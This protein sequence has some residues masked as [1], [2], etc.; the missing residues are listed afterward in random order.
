MWSIKVQ[1]KFLFFLP[2]FVA[3]SIRVNG[4]YGKPL[5][6]THENGLTTESMYSCA[7]D[8]D[9]FIWFASETG[10]TRFNGLNFEHFKSNEGLVSNSVLYF[11]IDSE[12]R[13][14][15]CTLNG[16]INYYWQ[17]KWY[18]KA[19]NIILGASQKSRKYVGRWLKVID[20]FAIS[21]I[22]RDIKFLY[23]DKN[24]VL[25]SYQMRN[26]IKT[27]DEII[28]LSILEGKRLKII[29]SKYTYLI[30]VESFLSKPIL[31]KPVSAYALNEKGKLIL[32][33]NS[34]I[35]DVNLPI[36]QK[37]YDFKLYGNDLYVASA[38]GLYKFHQKNDTTFLL[39]EKPL[40]NIS[41]V[42]LLIDKRKNLWVCSQFDGVY[43]FPFLKGNSTSVADLEGDFLLKTIPY[44]DF[45]KGITQYGKVYNFKKDQIDLIKKFNITS[46]DLQ[47]HNDNEYVLTSTTLE[48]NGIVVP[49]DMWYKSMYIDESKNEMYIGTGERIVQVLP[50]YKVLKEF[51]MPNRIYGITKLG[52]KLL[53]GSDDGA[54][55]FENNRLTKLDLGSYSNTRN[56]SK[57]I[58]TEDT[59]VVLLCRNLGV[60]IKK[61]NQHILFNEKLDLLSEPTCLFSPF[62]GVI[63]IGTRKGLNIV[64]YDPVSF[65]IKRVSTCTKF[66]GL[67]ENKINFMTFGTSNDELLITFNNSFQT[68][69]ISNLIFL[70][71]DAKVYFKYINSETT[72]YTSFQ[73]V[74][75]KYF[76]NDIEIGFDAIDYASLSSNGYSYRLEEEKKKVWSH[77]TGNVVKFS[78][79]Q[80]GKYTFLVKFRNRFNGEE[81]VASLNF[82]II[83]AFWQTF[84]FKMFVGLIMLFGTYLI[85]KRRNQAVFQK[86]RIKNELE[87]E[88]AT[89]ELEA[90]KAQINPHFIYNCLNSIQ[91]SIIKGNNKGAEK[92]LSVFSKLV[93]ETLDYSKTDFITLEQEMNYLNKYLEMEKLRFKDKLEF[94]VKTT[95][96]D[97][98]NTLI[99]CLLIQ[100]FVENAI[101]HGLSKNL[102]EVSYI[103]IGFTADKGKLICSVEDTGVGI[104]NSNFGKTE[105]PSGLNLS[106]KRAETYNRLYNMDIKIS[107]VNKTNINNS[108]FGTLASIVFPI[109]T[110]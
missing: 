28:I 23:F 105:M 22:N 71:Q 27:L 63:M 19:D 33:K 31:Y 54:F 16:D 1:F 50:E 98:S 68:I 102:N 58:V 15:A 26:V 47:I 55:E 38:K 57:I 104:S 103:K 65:K 107:I 69:P 82:R 40:L 72:T 79:L 67:I 21:F 53:I 101:K 78:D 13:V 89:L 44:K 90:I 30:N 18:G 25:R 109:R 3:L 66:N 35:W 81:E 20:N 97:K 100:P 76:E 34:K 86:E 9:G 42:N 12:G 91:H 83:P 80:P 37:I 70:N 61:N 59:T 77:T 36:D 62:K 11:D 87:K 92:Q 4:Q 10:A 24:S 17:G 41:C 94:E 7:E 73:K 45:Y 110:K 32:Y 49:L 14:W 99:P 43:F 74:A 60:I 2:I 64:H 46:Y 51:E 5:K 85:I 95:L 39:L 88:R 93:R 6:Y 48:K 96:Q 106:S 84:G 75:F 108:S 52:N 29:T 8:L 56:I